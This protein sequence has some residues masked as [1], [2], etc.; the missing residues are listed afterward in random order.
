[1][2]R[3]MP[4]GELRVAEP[5]YAQRLFSLRQKTPRF[6]RVGGKQH[7]Y[8]HRRLATSSALYT[9]TSFL[10]LR[11]NPMAPLKAVPAQ[12]AT[13]HFAARKGYS[14]TQTLPAEKSLRCTSQCWEPMCRKHKA[15]PHARKRR[16]KKGLTKAVLSKFCSHRVALTGRCVLTLI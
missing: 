4:L 9:T 3:N 1:M 5:L 8:L 10:R 2:C 7:K 13:C 15:A 12:R 16:R 6:T 11:R 14:I